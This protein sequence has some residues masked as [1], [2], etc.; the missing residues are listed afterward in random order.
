MF[1]DNIGNKV[2]SEKM[3]PPLQ[4]YRDAT[5]NPKA[6]ITI[7]KDQYYRNGKGHLNSVS[8]LVTLDNK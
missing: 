5:Q 8:S 7:G 1:F 2:E 3:N 6:Q 4:L